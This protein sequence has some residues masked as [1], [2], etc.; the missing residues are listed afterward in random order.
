M[1]RNK[2]RVVLFDCMRTREAAAAARANR[3]VCHLGARCRGRGM[4]RMDADAAR[5]WAAFRQCSLRALLVAR[6]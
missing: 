6:R 2:K 3:S 1:R 5:A 4:D